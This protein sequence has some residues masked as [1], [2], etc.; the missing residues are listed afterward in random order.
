[1]SMVTIEFCLPDD[2]YQKATAILEKQG[3]TIEKACILF[4]EETVRLGD[5]PFSYTQKD[6]EEAK[7]ISKMIETESNRR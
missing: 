6:I 4:L 2:L 7:K 5:L 3:Y 1:M